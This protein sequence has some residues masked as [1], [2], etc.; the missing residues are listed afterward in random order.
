MIFYCLIFKNFLFFVYLKKS[1]CNG[2]QYFRR[3]S[4]LRISQRKRNSFNILIIIYEQQFVSKCLDNLFYWPLISFLFISKCR[5]HQ[6]RL[7][8]VYYRE[9]PEKPGILGIFMEFSFYF[10]KL[11]NSQRTSFRGPGERLII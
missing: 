11:W 5:S 6:L 2:L 8:S 10:W 1:C 9:K 3:F 4:C 7:Q